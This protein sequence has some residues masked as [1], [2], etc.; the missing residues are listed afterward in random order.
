MT[1]NTLIQHICNR[2]EELGNWDIDALRATYPAH[3]RSELVCY[4]KNL[5]LTRGKIISD[6]LADEFMVEFDHE[7]REDN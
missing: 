1:L 4:V 5:G 3:T 2:A 6:I 7:I